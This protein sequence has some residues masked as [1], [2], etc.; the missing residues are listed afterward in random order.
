MIDVVAVGNRARQHGFTLVEILV[1]IALMALV[2]GYFVSSRIEQLK[3]Q[4][5]ENIAQEATSLGNLATAYRTAEGNADEWPDSGGAS[6]CDDAIDELIAENYLPAGYQPIA[7]A[8]LATSCPDGASGPFRIAITFPAID[9]DL[10]NLVKT[11][12]PAAHGPSGGGGADWEVV[13]SVYPPRRLGRQYTFLKLPVDTHGEISVPRPPCGSGTPQYIAIPQAVCVVDNDGLQGYY[14]R[15]VSGGGSAG[16][17]RLR[18][19]VGTLTGGG[20]PGTVHYD[21]QANVC[22]TTDVEVGVITYCE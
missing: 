1:S 16:P 18:L 7:S 14:F 19:M 11:A 13:Q 3:L 9:E 5:A 6:D 15:D 8:T 4:L 10:A 17:W 22:D 12:M 20:G 21:P 2:A